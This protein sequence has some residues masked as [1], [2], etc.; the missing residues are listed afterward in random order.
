[1][2]PL[3]DELASRSFCRFQNEINLV[4]GYL[5]ASIVL[6]HVHIMAHAHALVTEELAFAVVEIEVKLN[7]WL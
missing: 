6:F 1:M 4:T 7:M 2:L 3:P 5:R